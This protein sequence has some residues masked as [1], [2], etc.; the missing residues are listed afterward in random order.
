MHIDLAVADTQ[1]RHARIQAEHLREARVA[2]LS[3]QRNLQSHWKGE[4]MTHINSAVEEL[5]R[6]LAAAAADLDSISSDIVKVAESVK[7]NE[8]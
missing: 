2:L 1:A 6:K 5:L 7:R 4:E 8:E 3:Y